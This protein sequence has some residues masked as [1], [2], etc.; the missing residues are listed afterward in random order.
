MIKNIEKA[1]S[2]QKMKK[3]IFVM[4]YNL[5]GSEKQMSLEIH[6]IFS[7][8]AFLPL[9]S[10]M[11]TSEPFIPEQVNLCNYTLILVFRA[12]LFTQLP[13]IFNFDSTY[14]LY[15]LGGFLTLSIILLLLNLPA[16]PFSI[17]TLLL[18]L[19][20]DFFI[21]FVVPFMN[22]FVVTLG[23]IIRE[24]PDSA[25]EIV[26]KSL[27]LVEIFL[28]LLYTILYLFLKINP[29]RKNN[30]TCNYNNNPAFYGYLLDVSRALIL[31]LD[32][33]L[34]VFPIISL[35]LEFYKREVKGG[36]IN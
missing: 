7:Y 26:L 29:F 25:L 28:M 5:R 16:Q 20:L 1:D 27:V 17:F 19:S 31:A 6:L 12:F 32:S 30:I 35:V 10:I 18:R 3:H 11:F 23:E 4:Q 33:P 24:P 13:N 36:S 34:A 9:V 22:Y 2:V 15:G 8:L 14:M 21:F